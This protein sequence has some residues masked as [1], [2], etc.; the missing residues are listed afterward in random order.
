[1]LTARTSNGPL[2]EMIIS[3]GYWK[4]RLTMAADCD[5]TQQERDALLLATNLYGY[6]ISALR[7][8]EVVVPLEK[9]AVLF[10]SANDL[11]FLNLVEH[12]NGLDLYT[13]GLYKTFI[14]C[15]VDRWRR[16]ELNRLQMAAV[17]LEEICHFT[18]LIDD[19]TRVKHKV[20]DILH[21]SHPELDFDCFYSTFPGLIN[22]I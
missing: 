22:L 1:M 13:L 20:M 12:D 5:L 9:A 21:L 10:V 16:F 18:Y 15:R 19:E 3:D 2:R 8:P 17:I 6:Q 4:D 11:T 7:D 14:I